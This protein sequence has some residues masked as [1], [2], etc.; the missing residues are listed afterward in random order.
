MLRREGTAGCV[1]RWGLRWSVACAWSPTSSSTPTPLA[2]VGLGLLAVAVAVVGA[3]LVRESW[4]TVVSAAGSVALSWAVLEVL[5]DVAP[6]REL[7]A[8]VGGLATLCVA[9]AMMR[10]ATPAVPVERPGNHRS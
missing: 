9:V 10:R 2:W 8:V 3:G 6:D 7:E 1:L 4:L 5:R